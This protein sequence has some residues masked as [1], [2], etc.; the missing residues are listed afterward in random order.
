MQREDL[1]A[2]LQA[3]Y[4]ALYAIA[5]QALGQD[6][7]TAYASDTPPPLDPALFAG[8]EADIQAILAAYGDIFEEPEDEPDLEF[9]TKLTLPMLGQIAQAHHATHHTHH[10]HHHKKNKLRVYY[11]GIFLH[12]VVPKD[13]MDHILAHTGTAKELADWLGVSGV[14]GEALAAALHFLIKF[15]T[16]RLKKANSHSHGKGVDL[17]WTIFQLGLLVS[18]GGILS[19]AAQP[20]ISP[21]T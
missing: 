13:V 17:R 3:R 19:Q 6:P 10:H 21:A 4:D 14:E 5:E 16:S 15:E 8:H 1:P 2:D 11:K 7:A 18:S 12:L 9:E 20:F